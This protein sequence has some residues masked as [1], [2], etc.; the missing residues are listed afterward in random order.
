MV[1]T[2]RSVRRFQTLAAVAVAAL[3]AP[4]AL[5]EDDEE[6]ATGPI[7]EIVVSA[8][9]RDTRLMDSPTGWTGC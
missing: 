8:T 4:A 2:A 9:Y 3:T 7:E 1:S 6:G 5:A